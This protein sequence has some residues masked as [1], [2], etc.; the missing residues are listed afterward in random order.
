MQ[1]GYQLRQ[2]LAQPAVVS[3]CQLPPQLLD[4]SW[5][6]LVGE[7]AESLMEVARLRKVDK[8][9]VDGAYVLG[10]RERLLPNAI[11][12]SPL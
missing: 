7:V 12:P 6:E 1:G 3:P 10:P 5:L 11:L 9:N 8:V 2:L 4:D